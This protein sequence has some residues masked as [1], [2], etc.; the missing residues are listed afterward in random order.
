MLLLGARLHNTPVMGLQTGTRLAEVVRPIIDPNT[1]K[2]EAY[3]LEGQLLDETPSFLRIAD[4][5]EFGQLGFIVDGSEEF[6]GLDDVIKTKQ[7]YEL[8]FDPTGMHVIDEHK[9]KLGKVEDFIIDTDSFV[10]Q[11]LSIKTGILKSFNETGKLV[12]RSQITEINNTHIIV[13]AATAGPEPKR[14]NSPLAANP[15]YKNPFRKPKPAHE[16]KES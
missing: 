6:I 12:H 9:R 1:L 4:I 15:N 16:A 7:L 10:I 13:K 2:I 11:Q 14:A 5:R 3:E 8:N